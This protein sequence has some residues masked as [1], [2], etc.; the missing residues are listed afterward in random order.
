MPV[1][2]WLEA[3][4]LIRASDAGADTKIVALTAHALEEE[5]IEILEAGCNEFIRKPYRD[6]ELFDA[7]TKHLDVQFLYAE[8]EAPVANNKEAP[9]DEE[10]LGKIPEDLLDKLREAV[11]LLDESHCFK[12]AGEISDHNHELGE[13][14]RHMVEEFQYKKILQLLDKISS[15]RGK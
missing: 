12:A 5:R 9:L 4:R 8:E 11:V 10:Q 13:S 3:T 6:T 14:L 15:T 1:I 2:Y 7:L